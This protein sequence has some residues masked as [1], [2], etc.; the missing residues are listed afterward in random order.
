MGGDLSDYFKKIKDTAT[1]IYS[2]IK[3]RFRALEGVRL[4][5]R[6]SDRRFISENKDAIITEITVYR[7]PVQDFV[8][9][10]ANVLTIGKFANIMSKH[11]DEIYHLYLRIKLSNGKDI[12]LEKNQTIEIN[13][14]NPKNDTNVGTEKLP[15]KIPSNLTFGKFLENGLAISSPDMYFRYNPI[16]N[17]CQQYLTVLLKGSGIDP[18]NPEA[19]TF[20]FQ[21]MKHLREGLSSF[22]KKV[23]KGI[24]DLAAVANVAIHGYGMFSY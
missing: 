12:T 19:N 22:Q 15:L 18:L 20:I 16:S 13:N 3:S 6:P 14:F 24:T 2:G 11:Y 21:D 4:D 1:D 5:Y 23:F 17:N 10:L 9:K 7:T 8:K